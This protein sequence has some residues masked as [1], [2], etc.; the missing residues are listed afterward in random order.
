[1][2]QGLSGQYCGK[3][4]KN[5]MDEALKEAEKAIA[6]G[7]IPVGAVIV[8]HNRIIA[9]GHNLTLTNN[10]PTAHAEIVVIRQAG[11]ILKNYRLNDCDLY[12]T[13]EP[14]TMC[15]GAIAN[16]RIK[17]LYFGATDPKGG[18]VISGVQFFN[19]PTCHHKID[20]YD[21]IQSEKCRA[22]IRG[23]FR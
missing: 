18:A 16:A 23:F 20:I 3:M 15:A 7:E 6:V 13:L 17:R 8:H 2:K 19:Q 12:V 5:F 22:I 21:A 9:K 14:C 1:M 4:F 10:D 11:Q